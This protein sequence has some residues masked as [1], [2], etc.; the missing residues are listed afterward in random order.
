[1]QPLKAENQPRLLRRD[2]WLAVGSA[3]LGVLIVGFAI[4]GFFNLGFTIANIACLS[5]GTFYLKRKGERTGLFG[6]LLCI[7][8]A[9]GSF[10][11]ALTSDFG[12]NFLL[13]W[14]LVISDAV[15]FCILSR[16]LKGLG[17]LRMIFNAVS[18]VF[19]PTFDHLGDSM[20]LL[21]SHR[22]G[23]SANIKRL[24]IGGIFSLP[25]LLVV[26]P[27][28][29]SSDAAFEGLVESIGGDFFL[30]L[31]KI[32]LGLTTA[33]FIFSYFFSSR[34]YKYKN[35]KG[36]HNR[37][38][39]ID[40]MGATSFLG[41]ISVCYFFYLFSQL[42]YFFGGL[43]GILP[44][45]YTMAEYAR[46]GFF[47]ITIIAAINFTLVYTILLF[48]KKGVWKLLKFLQIFIN[49]FTMLLI[50][51]A[52][53]KMLMYISRFGM[54][55]LRLHTSLFLVFLLCV[56]VALLLRCVCK[57]V[58]IIRPALIS[59]LVILVLV[60][61][62]GSGRIVATYNTEAF[63][64]GKLQTLD[65]ETISDC[66]YASLEQ[67]LKLEKHLCGKLDNQENIDRYNEV[68]DALIDDFYEIYAFDENDEIIR[69][70]EMKFESFNLERWRS[71]NRFDEYVKENSE[72]VNKAIWRESGYNT[73]SIFFDIGEYEAYKI[74]YG[75]DALNPPTHYEHREIV[76]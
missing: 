35:H 65:V 74:L 18:S 17:D 24:L 61:I 39:G 6:I 31:L 72:F 21:F 69:K 38:F 41:V 10:V 7:L 49:V 58:C 15:Y 29:V 57:K 1:M 48:C 23:R 45:N 67:L 25:V 60:G 34:N 37:R 76:E 51:T 43:G 32:A 20:R 66:E 33:P 8:S 64:Q 59:A 13:F 52:I 28:L 9:L 44:E 11:F 30:W 70:T 14:L 55:H 50:V 73:D 47:E 56:G 63:L 2:C 62:L 3:V 26:V 4:F 46:R 12:V 68:T 53:A 16:G 5:I 40:P 22:D 71:L 42:A 54:T 75:D 19:M 27:L 36:W